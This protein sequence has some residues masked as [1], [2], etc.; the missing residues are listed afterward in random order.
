MEC[1]F[2]LTYSCFLKP[3]QLCVNQMAHY[4]LTFNMTDEANTWSTSKTRI[5]ATTHPVKVEIAPENLELE[6]NYEVT[7]TIVTLLGNVSSSQK[8]SK[9]NELL[10]Q[11]SGVNYS[12]YLTTG[13][14]MSL[15]WRRYSDC[16]I[17]CIIFLLARFFTVPSQLLVQAIGY[18]NAQLTW[19]HPCCTLVPSYT[20][21]VAASLVSSG[22]V[23][24]RKIVPV[25]Q[26]MSP[27]VQLSLTG[28]GCKYVNYTVSLYG[29]V[30][31]VST[32]GVLP[33][34]KYVR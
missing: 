33:A 4:V 6:R 19:L 14:H 22:E 27:L 18:E 7:V 11:S 16:N 13:R 21:A 15:C 26:T 29:G 5:M 8:F 10:S 31:A 3:P 2:R 17:L 24:L 25:L 34:R 30:R 28:Y 12:L 20:Y 23:I 1:I 9:Y 32:V